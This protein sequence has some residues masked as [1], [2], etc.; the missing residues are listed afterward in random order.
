MH[1]SVALLALCACASVQAGE[2]LQCTTI[3]SVPITISA[4]GSY[5]LTGDLAVGSGTAITLQADN[6][7]LDLNGHTLSG[8]GGSNST[9]IYANVHRGLRI[10][11]GTVR[12]F[13]NGVLIDDHNSPFTYAG[14][15]SRHE[16]NDLRVE[17]AYTGI[18]VVGAYSSIHHN[19]VMDTAQIGIFTATISG[20]GSG[21]VH[22]VANQVFNTGTTAATNPV[23]GI[24]AGGTGSLIQDNV[25]AK[26]RGPA[27]SAAIHTTTTGSFLSHN[28]ESDYDTANPVICTN[29]TKLEGNISTTSN[30]LTGCTQPSSTNFNTNF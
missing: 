12:N 30:N 6:V 27:N 23:Y 15:S 25:I 13:S 3:T 22:V 20:T 26:L 19:V 5:C 11:N 7:L 10:R 17:A 24:T 8:P 16:V 1:R 9:G 14:V 2:S 21:A 28:R 4:A 29:V 18:S